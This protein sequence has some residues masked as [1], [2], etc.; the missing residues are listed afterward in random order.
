MRNFFKLCILSIGIFSVMPHLAQAQ[1]AALPMRD[2]VEGLSLET[3]VV[4]ASRSKEALLKA[5]VSIEKAG[6]DFFKMSA[7]PS[8][9]DA[10]ENIKGLQMITPGM[11]FRILNSR[12]FANTTN[13]RFAQL[14]DGA[15]VQSPHI[16]APMGNALGPSDLDIEGVEIIPG[17]AATLFGMNATN[18]LANITTR[19][20]F[21]HQGFDVMHKTALTH[22]GNVS[23]N[24]QLFTET[25]IR[26]AKAWNNKV[27]VKLNATYMQGYD[28]VADDYTDMNPLGNS[29]TSL[30]AGDNPAYNGVNSYGDEASNRRT[31]FLGG[32]S[33]Q[34]ARTG[35]K[36]IDVNSYALQQI[37]TD[38]GVA[39][40]MGKTGE[41]RYTF[42]MALLDNTYQRA[43]RFRL[44]NYLLWQQALQY[45]AKGITVN[46]YMNAERTGNSYNLR[47][48]AENLDR[49]AKSDDVW[50]ADY[51]AAFHA[52]AGNG[53]NVASMHKQARTVADAGRLVPGA[54]DF[55]K[56]LHRLQQ[57]N[58]W[59]SGAALKVKAAFVQG[60]IVLNVHEL[61][62]AEKFKKIG[63][64]LLAGA[65]H[66][67]M[68]VQPDGNYFINPF[69][70]KQAETLRFGKSGIFLSATKN[71]LQQ[72]LRIGAAIRADKHDFFPLYLSPRFTAVWAVGKRQF[73]RAA[74][75]SGYRFPILFEAFSN[76]NSGG[77]KRVGGLP[78]MS[79]GIFENAWLESSIRKF[80][81]AVLYDM[82]VVGLRKQEAIESNQSILQRNSYTYLTPERTRSLE[83]GYR[84]MFAKQKLFVDVDIY[85]N[86]FK[87]F[88]A[89]ANMNVP[90]VSNADSIPFA[91]FDV[92]RQAQYR[93][94]TNS[95]STVYNYGFGI[96]MQYKLPARFTILANLSH[97]QLTRKEVQDGLEDGFNTPGWMANLTIA[98]NKLIG[99]MGAGIT[100]RWQ[101]SFYWQSFLVNG[102][103]SAYQ[104]VDGYLKFALAAG[105]AHITLGGTNLLNHY[106]VSFL[107]GPKIGGFYY[108]TL[109]WSL[110]S[111][112]TH[113]KS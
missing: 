90:L 66:R 45:T 34:V 52:A 27:A 53:Q 64:E 41:L 19:S 2:T 80:Q 111:K 49:V 16:S 24:P 62:Q 26:Y 63:L 38:A 81:Q 100:L 78:V 73:I 79:S 37:R 50:F 107:G 98:N 68:M 83:L 51:S 12:G 14:V 75:Q 1:P 20:A 101:S 92:G 23:V 102:Q 29:S 44:E 13:V 112:Q 42:R 6:A 97:A 71:L 91:L 59:D 72:R 48:M 108:T 89:Q 35:Y 4:S 18:G 8:F 11:G 17:I 96:G 9:F 77:V 47:S 57:I 31:L 5:P 95:R 15:D 74:W 33:Y 10:L 88:I 28:W 109:Q 40:K 46:V 60:D 67:S 110:P 30:A 93:M 85:F 3:V 113:K 22:V 70:D 54:A 104:T 103:V 25:A 32:K 7:S 94:Y 76:V 99:Q 43:N 36:E 61:W 65:D 55:T 105:R 106:Y 39:I 69:S 56:N 82:N 84:G 87:N 21:A 58:N 86:Q